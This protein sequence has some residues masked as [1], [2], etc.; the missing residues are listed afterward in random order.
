MFSLFCLDNLFLSLKNSLQKQGDT[1]E[2]KHLHISFVFDV[3]HV[4][5]T[6][7]QALQAVFRLS[8]NPCLQNSE[9]WSKDAKNKNVCINKLYEQDEGCSPIKLS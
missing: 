4:R 8:R 5:R 2:A 9:K 6:A 1:L 3:A 7:I